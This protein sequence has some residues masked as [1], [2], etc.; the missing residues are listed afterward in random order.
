MPRSHNAALEQREGRFYSICMNVPVS[1]VLRV[2]NRPVEILLHL[3]QRPWI[4][5]R[6]VSHNHFDVASDVCLDD[7]A[8]SRR[9]SILSMNQPE[10]AVALPDSDNNLFVGALAPFAGLA[11]NVSLVNLNCPTQFL[12]SSFEHGC[13]DAVKERIP[14]GFVRCLEHPAQLVRR[15]A[16]ARLAEQVGSEKPF[17]QR[18]MGVSWEDRPCRGRKLVAASIAV[19]L[20]AGRYAGNLVRAARWALDALLAIAVFR[21]RCGIFPRCQNLES[22]CKGLVRCSSRHLLRRKRSIRRT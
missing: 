21:G 5:G 18:Q 4:D 15:H 1:V 19:K 9:L 17:P 7:F 14:S 10:I 20:M 11:S 2:V 3:I 16:L 8:D 22:E 6:F 13:P 12:G